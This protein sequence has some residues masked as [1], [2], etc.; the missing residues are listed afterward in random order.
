MIRFNEEFSGMKNGCS[1]LKNEYYFTCEF[2]A[3]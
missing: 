1:S 3:N 2:N